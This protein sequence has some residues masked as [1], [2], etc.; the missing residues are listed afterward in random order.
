[1]KRT[2]LLFALL[3]FGG[4]I[5]AATLWLPNPG[6]DAARSDRTGSDVVATTQATPAAGAREPGGEAPKAPDAHFFNERAFP[7]GRIPLERW[8][9][10]QIEAATL[11]DAARRDADAGLRTETW[12]P[13]GPTNIGG[14]MT[15]LAVDPTDADIVYAAAA[16]GGVLR[17]FDGGQSWTAL[18]DDQPSL[19]VGAVA[20]DPADPAVIYAGTGEVNPGGGSV[21]YGGAG[22]FRSLDRGETWACLGLENTGSIGRIVVDPTNSERIFVAAMGQLWLDN[23]ERGVYRTTDGGATWERV[24]YIADHTG[25]VDLIVRPDNPE[26]ILAATWQRVRRPE[27]YDYGGPGCAVHKSVDG[28]DTWSLVGG[29]LPAPGQNGGR[30]GLSLCAS[31][32]DVMHAI[33]ADRTGYFAGLYKSADGGQ[34]W[35]RTSDGALNNVFASYGWWFGN[36]RTHPVNSGW[37]YVLGFDFCRSTNNGQSYYNASGGMHVDHHGLAF[38]AGANPVIYNGNDGGVYRSTNGGDAWVKLPD[39]PVTQIYRLALDANNPLALYCGTQDNGTCRTLTGALTDWVMILGGDGFQ[40]LVHPQSSSRIWA[41]YQYGSLYYSSNGGGSWSSAQNGIGS[42]DRRNWNSPLVQDPTSADRRYFGTQRLYRSSGNTSWTAISP[43]L[44][45]GPH[46]GGSGQVDGILTTIAVSP[47]DGQILWTGSD[48]GYVHGTTDG[49]ATWANVS[50]GL[51]ER[52]ITS[53]RADPF[54]RQTAY[55]TVSGWRWGEPLPHVY[56][57]RDL[58]LHWEPIAGNLPEAPV[59]DL[60]PSPLVPEHLLVATDVGVYQS[61]DGGATWSMVGAN[62]PRVVVTSLLIEPSTMRCYAGTYGRSFFVCTLADPSSVRESQA[63][64]GGETARAGRLLAPQPNPARTRT[65]IAWEQVGAGPMEVEIFSVAGRRV[66]QR[67][68]AGSASQSGV[69]HWDLRDSRGRPLPAG[70]YYARLSSGG[71]SLGRQTIIV[72]R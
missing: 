64:R 67:V 69:L 61:F 37:I 20:I 48:D 42:S 16:E 33:Y 12:E 19:S 23:P 51:P 70:A 9:A 72:E 35:T 59:N 46:Q 38:G 45:G 32:P 10:A 56:R 6:P 53:V 28:G 8:Q 29:G 27:Y 41:Q 21:A 49:G 40:P 65:T 25:C 66:W 39:L 17:T 44:T 7:L 71:H 68:I 24:L 30:I 3:L 18:F 11:R 34:T 5:M 22:I 15:D 52:W 47:L 26:V 55:V 1:M 63:D 4:L 13:A 62:L 57:T 54:E 14:R 60:A 43:D 31:Q 36:V 50:A 58:G 2:V